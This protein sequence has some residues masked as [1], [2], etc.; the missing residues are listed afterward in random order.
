MDKIK[1]IRSICEIKVD[2]VNIAIKLRSILGDD[3]NDKDILF[4]LTSDD[5]Y[6][7]ILQEYASII[8]DSRKRRAPPA[9]SGNEWSNRELSYY[10]IHVREVENIS[11]I[12]NI[13]EV[14]NKAACFLNEN[15]EFDPSIITSTRI[16][17]DVLRKFHNDFQRSVVFV[18]T[19]PKHESFVDCMVETYLRNILP[20]DNF[21]VQMRYT[22]KL[23]VHNSVKYATPDLA[24]IL[25]PE[26][27]VGVIIVEDKSKDRAGTT[28]QQDNTEAQIIA[29]AIAV[30]QQDNWPQNMPVFMLRVLS[31]SISIYRAMFTTDFIQSVERGNRRIEPTVVLRSAPTG[32]LMGIPGYDIAKLSDRKEVTQIICSIATYISNSVIGNPQE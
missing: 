1:V 25:Y 22:M 23:R 10:S 3:I 32:L 30:A 4:F 19:D 17:R 2:P 12:C 15:Q 6:G 9:S 27:R 5:K 20:Q 14:P 18:M 16:T 13:R 26:M 28:M 31:T 7:L 11:D 29:E 24:V 8:G 21:F